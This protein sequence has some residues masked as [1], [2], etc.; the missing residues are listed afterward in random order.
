MEDNL[1][2]WHILSFIIVLYVCGVT[3]EVHNFV[4]LTE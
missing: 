4:V 1:E 2:S 3:I